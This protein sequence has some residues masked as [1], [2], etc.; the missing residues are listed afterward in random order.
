MNILYL[1][2]RGGLGGGEISFLQ[3]L[4][5]RPAGLAPLVVLGEDGRLGDELR[6]RSLS[7]VIMPMPSLAP[8]PAA[9]TAVAELRRF[10]RAR[11]VALIHAQTPRAAGYAVL[12][13]TA[14]RKVVW[15]LRT[16][17]TWGGKEK[18]AAGRADAIICI[19]RAVAGC[20]PPRLHGRVAVIENGVVPPRA[21][22]GDESAALR[23]RWQLPGDMPAIAV[24]G[25]LDRGKGVD[26][27][28]ETAA[29]LQLLQPAVWLVAGDGPCRAAL[30]QAAR[31][32]ELA[33]FRWLGHLD[34]VAP[35]LAVSALLASGSASEGFG[36]TVAEAVL[37]GCPPLFFPVGGLAG[38]GLPAACHFR[39]RDAAV[40]ATQL[41]AA[42][43]EAPARRAA[44]APFTASFRERFSPAR[45]AAAVTELYRRLLPAWPAAD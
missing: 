27:L 17:G 20:V 23:A 4:D 19:S 39:E 1:N 18:F 3:F 40:I 32:R 26:L 41:A 10:C 44:L 31:A 29:A 36:R 24:I 8:G 35:V 45:H 13:R 43:R 16:V 22:P 6:R 42:L 9:L 5:Q 38:L 21:V 34:D 11:Q 15:H 30:E 33:N 7:P 25:R 28:I 12:L 14:E 37:A 2:H